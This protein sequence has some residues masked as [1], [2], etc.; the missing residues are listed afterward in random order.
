[1]KKL[2]L[3]GAASLALLAVPA[4]AAVIKDLGINPSSAQ[5]DFS[6]SVG[7]A[8]FEDDYTFQLVGGPQ[9]VTIASATNVYTGSTTFI[10]GFTGELYQIVGTIDPAGGGGDDIGFGA[11]TAL[12]CP[13]D[14]TGCQILAG[15]RLLDE[16]SYYLE[17]TGQGG[18]Q[19]GYGGNLTVTEVPGPLAGGGLLPLLGAFWWYARRRRQEDDNQPE[20]SN[21]A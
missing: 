6:N 21:V 9:F 5:G 19:S 20:W 8:L 11:V 15:R 7:G 3:A 18:G 14:P 12:P 2:L 1:M 10:S 17:I 16:G 4:S 13:G